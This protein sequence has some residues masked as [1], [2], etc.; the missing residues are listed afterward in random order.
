MQ[1][2]NMTVLLYYF[3]RKNCNMEPKSLLPHPRSADS[4]YNSLD[5]APSG[6]TTPTLCP[7][8]GRA[9]V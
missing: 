2:K 1:D 8:I 5:A 7:E 6:R 9:H 3:P 4:P